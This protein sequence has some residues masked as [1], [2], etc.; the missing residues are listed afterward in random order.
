MKTKLNLIGQQ[1][2]RLNNFGFDVERKVDGDWQKIGFVNGNGNSN[3][4][5]EYI[6]IDK[7]LTG[8]SKFLYRLKQVD[9]DGQFEYSECS[10]S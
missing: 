4:P 3:S 6:Y 10:R 8:G 5:K 1:K 7:N 9:N 2:Q